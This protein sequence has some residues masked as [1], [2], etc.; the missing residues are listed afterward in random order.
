METFPAVIAA[1]KT[2]MAM[3]NDRN[4]KKLKGTINSILLQLGHLLIQLE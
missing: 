4:C 1:R 3:K 2:K